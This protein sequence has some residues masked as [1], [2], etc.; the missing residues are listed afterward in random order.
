MVTTLTVILMIVMTMPMIIVIMNSIVMK[1]D[2]DAASIMTMIQYI[3]LSIQL[4]LSGLCLGRP[5]STLSGLVADPFLNCVTAMY[6]IP[7]K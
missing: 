2:N 5:L 4:S 3:D 7:N 6:R 1:I